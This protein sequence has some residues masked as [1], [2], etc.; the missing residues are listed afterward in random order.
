MS[1]SYAA[2][3]AACLVLSLAFTPCAEAS[4]TQPSP[5]VVLS[6]NV[7]TATMLNKTVQSTVTPAD[8]Q[9]AMVALG[10]LF[11]NLQELG[12]NSSVQ[13]EII[14]Q[15]SQFVNGLTESQIEAEYAY[16]SQAGVAITLTQYRN[17]VAAAIPYYQTMMRTF[18]Q[19][20]LWGIEQQFLNELSAEESRLV[21]TGSP[22]ALISLDITPHPHLLR[23]GV[24]AVM[25]AVFAIAAFFCPPLALVAAVYALED[26]FGLC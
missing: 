3:A 14:S 11:A 24:C 16:L 13:A 9:G 22:G 17:A 23:T 15:Q 1:T 26:A 8:I 25:A 5:A 2:S 18:Q 12:I 19:V 20:G 4:T 7:N 21:S 10:T 6:A